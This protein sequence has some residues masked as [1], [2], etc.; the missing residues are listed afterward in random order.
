MQITPSTSCQRKQPAL[1]AAG[2]DPRIARSTL[3]RASFLA[4][5]AFVPLAAY[6]L[7][8]HEHTGCK[9]L[10]SLSAVAAVV[11]DAYLSMG[12]CRVLIIYFENLP[13]YALLVDGMHDLGQIHCL[14]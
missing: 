5:L 1:W 4:R 3:D 6:D 9:W 2:A 12:N 10:R 7:P 11:P 8:C 13:I 14:I